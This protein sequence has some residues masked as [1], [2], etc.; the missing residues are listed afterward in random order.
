MTKVNLPFKIKKPIL[1]LGAQA[2]N[3]ICF[4]RGSNAYLGFLH[5]DLSCPDDLTAFEKEAKNFLRKHP[6]VIACDLH[7]EY[8]STKF[9]QGLI[10]KKHRLCFVQHHHAHIA[11]CMAE[12]HLENKKVIGVA[13][14]GTGLGPDDHIWGAEFLL[15]DY[16]GYARIGR[17]RE[18][19][20]VGAE[21]AIREPA[22]LAGAWF[23]F[24]DERLKRIC[25][26]KINSPL[27]SSMGRLFDAAASII[28][29][30]QKAAF[31]GQLAL[32]LERLASGF[33]DSAKIPSLRIKE[34]QSGFIIDPLNILKWLFRGTRDKKP[35]AELAYAFHCAVAKMVLAGCRII[36][37]ETK[38]RKVCLS[39]GVF[40]NKLLLKLASELL[41]RQGFFVFTQAKLSCNDSGI[42][43]GQ[44]AIANFN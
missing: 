33:S 1:A 15:C 23:G 16:R 26:A 14:D 41:Y 29:K 18:I 35:K 22:R 5:A 8:Q 44:A 31:E 6:R 39:G 7:P 40:Q 9:A 21:Q 43:L 20:L 42:S 27:A 12:N 38:V 19:P 11:S 24:K 32:E 10:D 28:L 2:K 34:I 30:K 3:T 4:A 36:R 25:A 17:L 37:R 13:F